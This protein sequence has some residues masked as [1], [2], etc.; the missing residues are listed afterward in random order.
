M[1]F[2][3]GASFPTGFSVG[4][5]TGAPRVRVLDTRLGKRRI[6][7]K[8]NWEMGGERFSGDVYYYGRFNYSRDTITGSIKR[9]DMLPDVGGRFTTKGIN[10]DSK[11]LSKRTPWEIEKKMLRGDDTIIGS[12]HDDV[13][14]GLKGDDVLIGG[15]GVNRLTGGPGSDTFVISALGRQI[16]TDFNVK[17]DRIE[18]PGARKFYDRF[19]WFRQGG[20]SIITRD[21][22]VLAEFLGAPNLDNAVFV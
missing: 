8:A 21:G 22:E 19:E 5:R 20:K 12:V 13:L 14:K 3:S 2:I 11:E 4:V 6:Y 10:I 18:L 1:A 15:G 17:Q 9:I 7:A 16:I